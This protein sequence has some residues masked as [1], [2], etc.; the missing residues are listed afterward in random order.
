[1][2]KVQFQHLRYWGDVWS[3]PL[4]LS[5]LFCK[6]AKL[7]SLGPV[8]R[9]QNIHI[10]R[11]SKAP[12]TLFFLL[13]LCKPPKTKIL[14]IRSLTVTSYIL[15]KNNHHRNIIFKNRLNHFTE[16]NYMIAEY[17]F[18]WNPH[19]TE[20]FPS[21]FPQIHL[22]PKALILLSLT[23]LNMPSLL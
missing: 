13:L 16:G 18:F 8:K 21:I 10:L 5:R 11:W 19:L 14:Y 4:S 12:A 23:I 2:P 15:S 6:G 17:I 1:M 9:G 20:N 3:L 7:N 22:N